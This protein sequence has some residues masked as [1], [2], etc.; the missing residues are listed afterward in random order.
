MILI[1]AHKVLNELSDVEESIAFFE[2]L[3]EQQHLDINLEEL[4]VHLINQNLFKS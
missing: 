3:I 1:N 4:L 2:S